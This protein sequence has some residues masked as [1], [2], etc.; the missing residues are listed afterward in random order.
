LRCVA[1]SPDAV[2]R[3]VTHATRVTPVSLTLT[4]GKELKKVIFVPGKILNL[5]V[6]GK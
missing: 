5:I 2:F 3:R 4:Q 6:P 1:H